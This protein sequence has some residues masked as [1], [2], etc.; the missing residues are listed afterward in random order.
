MGQIVVVVHAEKTLRND[1]QHALA[2]IESCPVKMM[3][4]NQA[5]AGAGEGYGYGGYGQ[6]YGYGYG[7]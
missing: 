4:L 6:G 3:V 1:V 5:K 7:S 2:T